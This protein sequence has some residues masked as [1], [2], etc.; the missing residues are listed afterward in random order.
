MYEI[1][2]VVKQNMKLRKV[3]NVLYGYSVPFSQLDFY[4]RALKAA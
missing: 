4:Y 2:S 3:I 1:K